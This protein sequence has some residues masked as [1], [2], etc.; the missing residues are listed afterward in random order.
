[1]STLTGIDRDALAGLFPNLPSPRSAAI[2]DKS[3][4]NHLNVGPKPA[5]SDRQRQRDV[6]QGLARIARPANA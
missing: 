4:A 5:L 3:I 1:M 6:V 2:I